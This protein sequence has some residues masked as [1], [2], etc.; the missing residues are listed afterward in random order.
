MNV[1]ET[2]YSGPET[3]SSTQQGTLHE[4]IDGAVAKK[5]IDDLKAK[6]TKL[7]FYNTVWSMFNKEKM[8]AI[9]NYTTVIE[10]KFF[11][12][13]FPDDDTP[14]KKDAPVIIMQ[15]T[16]TDG[17]SLLPVY[18][19]SLGEKYCPPPNDTTCGTIELPV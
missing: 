4:K 18:E 13:V 12:G 7:K 2:T 9:Y 6:K 19:Y 16:K 15:V 1:N 3:A 5:M 11:L 17:H 10:V 14:D 8:A